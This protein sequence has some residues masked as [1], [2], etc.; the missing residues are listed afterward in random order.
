MLREDLRYLDFLLF[1][2]LDIS[3]SEVFEG[4]YFVTKAN[5]SGVCI[6]LLRHYTYEDP[7]SGMTFLPKEPTQASTCL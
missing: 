6:A 1:S 2:E 7:G 4:S 3:R 5:M